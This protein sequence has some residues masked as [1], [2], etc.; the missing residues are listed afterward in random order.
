MFTIRNNVYNFQENLGK[1]I[2]ALE[3]MI[4]SGLNLYDLLDF[5]KSRENNVHTNKNIRTSAKKL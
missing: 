4:D 2:H 3:E 5:S 1:Y